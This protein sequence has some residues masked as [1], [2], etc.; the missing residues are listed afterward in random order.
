MTFQYGEKAYQILNSD[1]LRCAIF[2]SYQ[3]NI[4]APMCA[5]EVVRGMCARCLWYCLLLCTDGVVVEDAGELV[6][7][8]E[9]GDM[10]D[11]DGKGLVRS[12][13][14]VTSL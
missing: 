14:W 10:F 9:L 13:G 7:G 3:Q 4:G 6:D 11:A 1:M 5:F 2:L 8:R 12:L